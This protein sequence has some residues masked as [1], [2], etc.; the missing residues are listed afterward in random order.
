MCYT[1]T[2]LCSYKERSM[3]AV[4]YIDCLLIPKVVK[5]TSSFNKGPK[6]RNSGV[7]ERNGLKSTGCSKKDSECTVREA[8]LISLVKSGVVLASISFDRLVA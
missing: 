3:G 6:G 7:L 2:I 4:I 8:R 5:K 1:A